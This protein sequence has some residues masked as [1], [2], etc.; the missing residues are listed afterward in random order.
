M[1]LYPK[2][3]RGV[4]H[5]LDLWRIGEASELRYL[6]EF[7]RS[8]YQSPE[9]LSRSAFG[10]I[11]RLLI[12][13]SRH[14]GYYQES[15]RRHDVDPEKLES[16]G[17]LAN[18]PILEKRDIQRHCDEM[19]ADDHA[20]HDLLRDQTGGSTG[21]PIAY[22]YSR[23]RKTSRAA[24]TRRHNR[25]AGFDVGDKF[26]LVWG[27]S[28]DIPHRSLKNRLRNRILDRSL[29]LDTSQITE[30]KMLAFNA[31]LKMFR[32]KVI[33]AYARSLTFFA[34]FLQSRNETFYQPQSIITSAELLEESDRTLLEETFGAPVFNRYGCREFSVV[35]SECSE[36]RGM[37]IM[38]EGLYL[39][40]VHGTRPT[41]AGEVGE[42]LVTD[43]LNDAMPLIRY[44]IG[45]MAALDHR[46]CACGRGL[47]LVKNIAGRVTDF[48]VGT[49]GRFVSGV[50]LATYVV[51]R[52]PTLGQV[53]LRQERAGEILYKILR[54]NGDTFAQQDSDYLIDE[55]RRYV[56]SDTKVAFEFVE[57][58]P[59]ESSG[60]QLFCRS[61]A[62]CAFLSGSH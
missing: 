7:E 48:I 23:E 31:A 47:P 14:C 30:A 62:A 54:R 8:Q 56:G 43:L 53:Q 34:K 9:E 28:R 21:S 38:A 42:L 39:E 45:D 6:R 24:A 55:T 27:A 1:S 25:W 20:R 36:H 10:R 50:F 60:K 33:L 35:A 52:R 5:P 59:P 16:F 37:H 57:E 19:I 15:F 41:A 11:K 32:P 3:V 29:T 46:P 18:Y 49:D 58:M 12:H 51:A 17:D 2:I 61:S 22:Y 4:L 40:T 44:R 26:A 13:A